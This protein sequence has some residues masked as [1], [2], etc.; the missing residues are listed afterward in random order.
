MRKYKPNPRHTLYSPRSFSS[1]G[2]PTATSTSIDFSIGSDDAILNLGGGTV[3]NVSFYNAHAYSFWIKTSGNTNTIPGFT[4]FLEFNSNNYLYMA[5]GTM[6]WSHGGS[7]LQ[8]T[9]SFLNT[10]SHVVIDA[11]QAG[12]PNMTH[13]FYVNGAI[14]GTRTFSAGSYATNSSIGLAG[15]RFVSANNYLDMTINNLTIW[16]NGLS[17]ANVQELYNNGKPPN[18][19]LMSFSSNLLEWWK[20]GDGDTLNTPNGLVEQ[21]LGQ[22]GT[23]NNAGAVITSDH[24]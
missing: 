7:T 17:L 16:D 4:P 2:I 14:A 8:C 13:S 3:T 20:L 11:Q 15:D 21:Q 1:S 24:P 6:F 10:W 12:V 9:S 23:Q 19:N 18:P 5:F 22:T